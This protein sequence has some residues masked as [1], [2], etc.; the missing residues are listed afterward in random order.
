MEL[1]NTLGGSRY[2]TSSFVVCALLSVHA[3]MTTRRTGVDSHKQRLYVVRLRTACCNAVCSVRWYDNAYVRLYN[4]YLKDSVEDEL[5]V[6]AALFDVNFG[7]SALQAH[8]LLDRAKALARVRMLERA[9]SLV[10]LARARG[11]SSQPPTRAATSSSTSTTAT[12]VFKLIQRAPLA[13]A[14]DVSIDDKVS[15]ELDDLIECMSKLDDLGSHDAIAFYTTGD[16]K[17]FELAAF[18][19]LRVLVVPAGEAQSERVFSAAGYFD[20]KRRPFTPETLAQLTFV[21]MNPD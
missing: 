12:G 2:V 15:K 16:G 20:A 19:A 11:T 17:K 7:P 3:M 13:V 18:V 1:T 6:L 9:Q 4:H 8:E 14:A 5:F 21:K 10:S